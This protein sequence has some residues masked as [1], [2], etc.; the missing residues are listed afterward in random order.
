VVPEISSVSDPFAPVTSLPLMVYNSLGR[1][2]VLLSLCITDFLPHLLFKTLIEASYNWR[3]S[4]DHRK[5]KIFFVH[6]GRDG[7][8]DSMLKLGWSG[9]YEDTETLVRGEVKEAYQRQVWFVYSFIVDCLTPRKE[10][11]HIFLPLPCAPEPLGQIVW[12]LEGL[13]AI[14]EWRVILTILYMV[15]QWESMYQVLI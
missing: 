5:G 2:C 10:S 3:C 14:I 13:L 1:L 9:W 15:V 4:F 8:L 7:C 12:F 6:S 11:R